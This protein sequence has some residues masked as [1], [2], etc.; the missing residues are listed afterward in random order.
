MNAIVKSIIEDQKMALVQVE[1]AGKFKMYF[2]G[3]L[4]EGDKVSVSDFEEAPN[5]E[6]YVRLIT[7]N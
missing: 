6:Y 2:D 1:S 5:G 4:K 3:Q 7:R